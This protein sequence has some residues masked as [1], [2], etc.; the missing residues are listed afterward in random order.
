MLDQRGVVDRFLA[1]GQM[2]QPDV[3][4]AD[5]PLDIS[6]FPT[7]HNYVLALWQRDIERI[8]AGWVDELGVRILRGREVVGVRAGRRRR[9]RRAV[10]RRRRC[11]PNTSSGATADA[12]W[13]ARR[14]ASTSPGWDP[15]TSC[16]IAEV[17]MTEAPEI[18]MR[19]EGGGIGPVDPA[20]GGG[21]YG[22]VLKEAERRRTS[23]SPTLRGPPR[24]RSI[25]AY[26][27][28]FGA[29]NPT[30]DLALHRHDPPGRVRT[31]A[32]RVLLAGDAAH[33][34]PRRAGRASTSACRTR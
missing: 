19:R 34:H 2:T 24:R 7:R 27:T 6:D 8:L 5:I 33:V 23:A 10:R 18:G 32:G 12:A 3:G 26:G 9:R 22:V 16:I 17:E 11:G 28:D 21:P 13:S 20:R 1:E 31:A 14:P 4:Y 30:L 29:H 15:S 25:A